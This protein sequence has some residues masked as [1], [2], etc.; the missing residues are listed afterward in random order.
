MNQLPYT[1]DFKSEEVRLPQGDDPFLTFFNAVAKH[2][3][4]LSSAR[5]KYEESHFF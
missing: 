5:R 1:V 4:K 2:Q 3:W